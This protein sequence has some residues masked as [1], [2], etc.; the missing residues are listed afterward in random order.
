MTRRTQLIVAALCFRKRLLAGLLRTGSK[1]LPPERLKGYTDSRIKDIL[2]HW[3]RS[4]FMTPQEFG[5]LIDFPQADRAA[6]DEA[7]RHKYECRCDMC[8]R[9]WQLTGPE[10]AEDAGMPNYTPH[11]G[12]FTRKEILG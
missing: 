5:N 8:R 9:Y 3:P 6:L 10:N 12:P 2:D 1:P 11:F 7:G 4:C